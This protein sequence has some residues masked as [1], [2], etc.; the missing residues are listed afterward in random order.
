V[1][2]EDPE[3]LMPPPDYDV[4]VLESSGF[5]LCIDAHPTTAQVMVSSRMISDC[6]QVKGEVFVEV[7]Q[8]GF[9]PYRELLMVQSDLTH[10]VLLVP[11]LQEPN[12]PE[13]SIPN[14]QISDSKVP[15]IGYP[16]PTNQQTP[17]AFQQSSAS[18]Q[19]CVTTEPS[20]AYLK[21]NGM[22]R[23]SGACMSVR[24][25]AEV[26]VEADGYIAYE[27]LLSIPPN[28]TEVLEHKVVL[29]PAPKSDPI[30]Y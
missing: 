24:N 3:L 30:E 25:A 27:K 20:D 10:Q 19:L 22:K 11:I 13:V 1:K 5:T 4:E 14:P 6:V 9:A 21:I 29:Q 7:S 15:Q 17:A 18:V 23:T 28:Q 26:S 8:E 12:I 16:M 2:K